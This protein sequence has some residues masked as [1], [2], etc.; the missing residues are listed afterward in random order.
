MHHSSPPAELVTDAKEIVHLTEGGDTL[1]ILFQAIYP[2]PFPSLKDLKFD[3][4]MLLAEAA[5]KYQVFSMIYTCKI[6]L[7][8]FCILAA[9]RGVTMGQVCSLSG[10]DF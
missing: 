3:D 1:E 5:E 7:E 6:H 4:I 9:L 10:G 2:R 8:K